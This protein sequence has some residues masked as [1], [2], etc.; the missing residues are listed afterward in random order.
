MLTVRVKPAQAARQEMKDH[1]KTG[2]VMKHAP[3]KIA[4]VQE[5]ANVHLFK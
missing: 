4:K 1:L 3:A 2:A 5:A